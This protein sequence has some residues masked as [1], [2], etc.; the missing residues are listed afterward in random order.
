MLIHLKTVLYKAALLSMMLGLLGFTIALAASGDLDI[1]FSGD[2]LVT[3]NFGSAPGRAEIVRG[4]TVQA[5]GKIVVVG[6]SLGTNFDFALARYN[7]NGSL[8]TTFSGDGRVITNFGGDDVAFDVVVQSDGKI[9]AVGEKCGIDGRCDLALA[10][11][12][13]NGTLDTTFSTDGKVVKDVNGSSNGGVAVAMQPDGKIVVAGY[14]SRTG[15]TDFAIYRYNTNGT[16]DTT[17]SGDGVSVGFFG[18]GRTD[19]AREL[20]L[21]S[22]GKI[23]VVGWSAN[24][25]GNDWAIVRLNAN[26]TADTTFSGDGRQTTNFGFQDAAASVALQSDR[27]S[28]V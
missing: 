14:A 1:T 23:I 7:P 12:N 10:R 3:T 22:D 28:V 18:V 2:G 21:Q 17:F 4:I 24:E 5:D 13:T 15:T 9:I 27:K 11:Y 6:E 26:G 19:F 25:S 20:V 8:D 16:L